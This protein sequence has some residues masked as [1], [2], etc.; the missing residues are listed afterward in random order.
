MTTLG[1]SSVAASSA[2]LGGNVTADG[3][4]SV[5]NR[6]VCYKTSATVTISDNKTQ[7]G[8]GT[9]AFSNTVSSL[10]VNT[11]Y[12]YVA[13]AQNSAGT[14]L[15]SESNFWTL[16]NVPSAPTVNN[17]TTT[18]L[19]VA[20]N[21]NSNPSSTEF[22]IKVTYGA[23]TK[24]VQSD[25]TLGDSEA[26]ATD[27]TWGTKTVTGLSSST[28][29]TFSVAAR[30]GANVAT[31]YSSTASGTTSASGCSER[32]T[33][34]DNLGA[35]VYTYYLG[36]SL[37]YIYYYELNTDTSGWTSDYGLGT[38]TDG[39]GWTWRSATY[40]S[41]NGTNWKWK[42]NASEHQF[43]SVGNWYY[44]GRFVNGSCTYYADATWQATSAKALDATNYF[45]VSALNNPGSQTA[46]AAGATNISLSWAKDAQSHDVMIV[47]STDS[48]FTDPTGGTAYTAGTDTIGGDL[49]VYRGGST[50]FMD[51]NLSANTTY[52]YKFYSE[53]WSYYSAGV[54][55]NA[56]TWT[57]PTLTSPTATS[58]G[59]TTATLGAN[60]TSLGGT[61]ISARGTVWGT[62]ANPTGN[63][64][65]EGGTTTGTFSEGRTGFSQGTKYYYRGYAVNSVGTAYSSD[66]SFHTEPGQAASVQFAA[67]LGTTMTISWTA[68]ADADGAIVVVRAG[69]SA[70]T[71]PTDGTLHSANAAFGSGADLGSGSYV[72]YRGSGTTVDVTGLSEGTTYYVEV[73]AYKGTA[74]DS[75]VDQG[76]NYRQTSP[77]TGN[78]AT[79]TTLSAPTGL[80][81]N[82]TND[83]SFT[84]N[85]SAVSGATNYYIDVSTNENF[86]GGGGGDLFISEVTDPSDTYQ[87]KYIELYNATGSAIDFGSTS[88]WISRQANGTTWAHVQLTGTVANGGTYVIAYSTTFDSS[89]SDEAD[90]Y[91]GSVISGNGDDGYYLL[92]GGG[93]GTGTLVDAYGVIGEQGGD[94]TY[95]DS[96][97]V[98]N[99]SIG[100]ANATWTSSEWTITGAAVA[101]MTPHDHTFSGGGGTP[102]YVAGYSNRLVG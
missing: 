59:Q 49:V 76:I 33:C 50:S 47:R 80:Y 12:Y 98:R 8:S 43:T 75:G 82:P 95:T 27:A 51:T 57:T 79:C 9:G 2:V 45:T 16:A 87:A 85:W 54:T 14:S 44:A 92:T 19:D 31:A 72:V 26:W 29:Y 86:G 32:W 81:A 34:L 11:R 88:W 90:Q 89:F 53:N 24:Y 52:Y 22:A 10:S 68:G 37:A 6:G 21:E 36:D 77:A 74:A 60:V 39:S 91:D 28:E 102:D 94:W 100:D 69:N 13:Y 66:G 78:Q 48:S 35:P 83:T 25:G 58:I 64:E 70:V 38:T 55:A 62:S 3:G 101:D 17:P 67:V 7:I 46:T 84:A 63:A 30:N 56:T 20:V 1:E 5:T 15:G 73:F 71:D 61:T 42:N 99:S 97:A 18:S 23:T 96:H 41:N 93:Y 65:P 40:D 4:A